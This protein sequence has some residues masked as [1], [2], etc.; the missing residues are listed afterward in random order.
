MS[1]HKQTRYHVMNFMCGIHEKKLVEVIGKCLETLMG[2]LAFYYVF[3]FNK[4]GE[5][6]LKYVVRIF[7]KSA[8]C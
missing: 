3:K 5:F 1:S 8:S 6:S 2:E 4:K 7:E